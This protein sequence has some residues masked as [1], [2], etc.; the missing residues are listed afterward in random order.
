MKN[1]ENI[2]ILVDLAEFISNVKGQFGCKEEL[3]W[4]KIMEWSQRVDWTVWAY[5]VFYSFCSLFLDTSD[6]PGLQVL[7]QVAKFWSKSQRQ[8]CES[9]EWLSIN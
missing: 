1:I 7:L 8:E 3:E 4:G 5:N 6:E 2:M 9:N